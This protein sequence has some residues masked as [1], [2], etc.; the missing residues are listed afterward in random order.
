MTDFVGRAR[1]LVNERFPQAVAA[2]LGGSAAAGTATKTSD[3]D[4]LVVLPEARADV[5][6]VETMRYE[7][8]LVEAF[9]YGPVAL[10]RW[11][12]KGRSDRRPVLD[13]LIGEGIALTASADTRSLQEAAR[14]ALNE[15]PAPFSGDELRQRQYS[16]SGV[17]DDLQDATDS[18]EAFVLSATAWRESAE[19]AL[20]IDQRW[21]GSGKWLLREVRL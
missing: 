10:Q 13:K 16:L 12:E 18:G 17:L 5:S 14:T 1:S 19:L 15:G 3:L 7:G 11:V 9:V 21:L 4:L 2:F 8:Q 6:Y 20:L